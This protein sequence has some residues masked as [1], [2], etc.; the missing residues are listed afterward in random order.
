MS[1]ITANGE[2]ATLVPD[3]GKA[4]THAGGEVAARGAED[5][6]APAGHVLTTVIAYPFHDGP[7]AAVADGEA[8]AREAS[9]VQLACR[10]AI[11]HDITDDG[12]PLGDESRLAGWLDDDASSREPF[13]QI[14]VRVGLP[15]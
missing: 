4:A 1:G 5:H 12:V 2:I 10:G 15:A 13:G 3:E 11:E 9:D 8:L 14:V 7:G 6:H